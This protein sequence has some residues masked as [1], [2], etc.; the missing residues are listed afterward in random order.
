MKFGIAVFVIAAVSLVGCSTTQQKTV[1][2]D[3][4]LSIANR[5]NCLMCH[6][7]DK[8]VI[9]PSFKEVA[10]KYRG[11][12]AQHYLFTK[13]RSGGSGVWG[14]F[15][16]PPILNIPDDD[17]QILI[18]WI[19]ALPSTGN[20]PTF[21]RAQSAQGSQTPVNPGQERAPS[22]QEIPPQPREINEHTNGEYLSQTS[23]EIARLEAVIK[24]DFETNQKSSRRKFIGARPQEFRFAQYLENWVIKVERIGNMNYPEEA[25]QNKINGSL[26]LTVSIRA[27]GSVESIEVTRSSGQRVLDEAAMRIVKLASPFDPFPDDIRRDTDILSITR[28]WNFIR[29][30]NLES[31]GGGAVNS[32]IPKSDS[33]V[34]SKP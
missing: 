27:D 30:D 4:A 22:P 14:G 33:H 11:Q 13:V 6:S 2:A 5:H 26:Q 18:Q 32:D 28:T 23:L 34:Q 9:G 7:V 10:A 31:T 1:Q 25:R 3:V 16:A 20:E 21:N 17:L 8:K 12:D 29:T 15:P 24:K 19:A